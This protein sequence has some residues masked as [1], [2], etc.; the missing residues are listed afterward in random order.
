M[1]WNCAQSNPIY[2]VHWGYL[3]KI[4]DSFPQNFVIA[5]GTGPSNVYFHKRLG[6]SQQMIVGPHIEECCLSLRD[7]K[8]KP[9]LDL[10]Q[11]P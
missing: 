9:S 11:C 7:P 5:I 2:F 10:F 6:D 8:L 1:H 3:L 4:A